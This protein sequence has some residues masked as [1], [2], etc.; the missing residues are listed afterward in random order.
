MS[1]ALRILV[2]LLLVLGN[3][4]FVAAE[5]ALVTARRTRLEPEA[6]AGSRRARAALDRMDN[7]VGFI[8]TV[9]IGITVFSIALGAVGEPLIS[10]YFDSW[11]SHGIAFA[12][13][14]LILTYLSVA[15]GELVPKAIALQ[16]AEPIAKALALPLGVLQRLTAPFVYVL[17]VSANAVTRLF[18]I[19][20][21]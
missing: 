4:V 7:P 17:Q 3:A 21:A 16:K 2:V 11:V 6:A 5:Y 14:F 8:S 18:G 13:S 15:L 20:P 9:Q 1:D 19:M 10:D 12:L